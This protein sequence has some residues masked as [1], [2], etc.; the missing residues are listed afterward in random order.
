MP[1]Q[2]NNRPPTAAATNKKHVLFFPLLGITLFF[3][4]L[5]RMQFSFPIWF[6]EII[7]KALFFGFPVWIYVSA[8]GA[9]SV[10]KT[11]SPHKFLPGILLGLAVGGV[12]G[13]M[14]AL[15]GYFQRSGAPT[16]VEL[17]MT[18]AFWSEFGLA[19]FTA[20]WE[21]LLFYS[22]TLTV[23]GEVF[24]K[25]SYIR[26][27]VVVATIFA[28]FHLPNATLLNNANPY[29]TFSFLFVLFVFGLG[30]ALLFMQ[31]RNAYALMLSHAIWGMVLLI[32]LS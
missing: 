10:V 7:G 12:F 3:W 28:I 18:D 27:A 6:D 13:F 2:K 9:T 14:T 19:L 32:H 25:W 11:L 5:Y 29:A 20:F 1:S 23:L 31:K 15:F 22:L 30:Q 16:Q 17:F 26:L 21:T 4:V 8:V 24:P